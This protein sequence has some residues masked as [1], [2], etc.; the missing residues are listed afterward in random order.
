[1]TTTTL[2][3]ASFLPGSEF[4]VTWYTYKPNPAWTP[5]N[6][7]HKEIETLNKSELFSTLEQAEEFKQTVSR[8][9][10]EVR[11]P[12]RKNFVSIYTAKRV[13]I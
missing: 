10:V 11:Q 5:R 3:T 6:F 4:R 12:G 9:Y 13:E 1:M 7:K 8:S 2:S